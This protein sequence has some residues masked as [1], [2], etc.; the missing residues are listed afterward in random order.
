M[1][2]IKTAYEVSD[3]IFLSRASIDPSYESI[4]EHNTCRRTD[5][6][7][8]GEFSVHLDLSLTWTVD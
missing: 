8:E 6:P 4:I 3:D 5:L 1:T 7:C 2:A